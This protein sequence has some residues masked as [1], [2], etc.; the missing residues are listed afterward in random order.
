[1]CAFPHVS[2]ATCSAPHPTP[3]LPPC[4]YELPNGSSVRVYRGRKLRVDEIKPRALPATHAPDAQASSYVREELSAQVRRSQG[5]SPLAYVCALSVANL[6][7][8]Q[9]TLAAC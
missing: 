4:S 7:P 3:H 1:M 6:G 9:L 8:G 5:G 2:P